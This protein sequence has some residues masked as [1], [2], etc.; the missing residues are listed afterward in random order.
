[1]P[2]PKRHSIASAA[3][4]GESIVNVVEVVKGDLELP[5]TEGYVSSREVRTKTPDGVIVETEHYWTKKGLTRWLAA[6]P[7]TMVKIDLDQISGEKNPKTARP[8]PVTID[9]FR[10]DVPK[11]VA[12]MV[13]VPIAQI[14][15]NMQAEYRT[16]QSQGIDL[17]RIDPNDPTDYGLEIPALAAG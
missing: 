5:S 16:A 3:G 1:M 14:I 15:E 12:V 17:Y 10:I 2:G 4:D 6:C 11:G 9:G 13:P 7:K 8:W